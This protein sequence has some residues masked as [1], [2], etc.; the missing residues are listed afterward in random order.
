MRKGW[1]Q[2]LWLFYV[3]GTTALARDGTVGHLPNGV[4]HVSSGLELL[5]DKRYLPADFDQETFDQVWRVW[6]EPLRSRAKDAPPDQ[7][8][9]MAYRRYGL[10]ERPGDPQHR[11]LQYV[12]DEEGNW[13]MNC[14]ACHQGSVAGQ[15]VPGAPNTQFALATLTEEMRAI[16]LW[17]G[18]SLSHMDVGSLFVPLGDTIGTTNAVMFGVVL[19]HYRD[20]GLNVYPD[21]PPPTNLVNHDH[22]APA[23]WH[24]RTKKMIYADGFAPKSHRALMPFLMVKQNGPEKFREWE[25]DFRQ[26]EDYL[27]SLAPPAYPGNIERPLADAGELIFHRTCARCHGT[28]G[29]RAQWPGKVV[30]LEEVATDPVRLT[31]LSVAHRR[32]WGR[33]WFGFFGERPVVEDPVGYVAPPLDGVWASPPYFHNGSVP[34]LWHVL[35]PSTRPIVWRRTAGREDNYDHARMGLII[36]E[37]DEVPSDVRRAAEQRRYFDTRVPG[38]TATGHDF[39]DVL[40]EA[41]KRAVLEYL[42]TL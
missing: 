24:Y 12:V 8:R 31:A 6:P 32:N 18:K 36:T 5:L 19:M 11:P 1:F 38:K 26:I 28:Y 33:S 10:I 14:L 27:E 37:L 7:R 30:P 9:Q 2:V 40:D 4:G 15:I 41:E 20:A 25:D 22:D 16:K 35:H 3:A 23:W 42:K 17:L 29:G 13:T 21:R 34:T 39:A